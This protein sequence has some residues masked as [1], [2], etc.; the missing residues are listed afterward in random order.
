VKTGGGQGE[1]ASPTNVRDTRA[2]LASWLTEGERV[3]AKMFPGDPLA[4][5]M[6]LTGIK[7]RVAVI[8]QMQEG[9]QRQAQGQLLEVA[10]QRKP[11]TL[12]GLLATPA[13]RQAWN[14]LDPQAKL[15]LI[16]LVDRNANDV[17]HK[18]N[19]RML[20]EAFDRIHADESDPKKIRNRSELAQYMRPGGVSL[21]DHTRLAAELEASRTPE[22]NRFLRDVQSARGTVLRMLKSSPMG[23]AMPQLAEEAAYRW[24][25]D[26]DTKIEAM[27]KDGKDP[28]ELFVPSSKEYALA[29]ERVMSYM[30]DP[31]A[32]VRDA[33]GK[34]RALPQVKDDADYNK[35]PKGAKYLDPQG[36]E[37]TKK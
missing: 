36:I 9:V 13:A 19:P 4:K 29:P 12:D 35:L 6:I 18:S 23:D 21:T 16:G 17:A 34:A 8:S 2:M 30:G 37:R 32:A 1:G 22:G 5:D 14:V 33:A 11:T 27:R 3:A 10:I 20:Q 15:G 26:L 28:R 25:A 7:G 31:R 24:A